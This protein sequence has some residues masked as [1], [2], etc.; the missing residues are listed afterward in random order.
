M[1]NLQKIEFFHLKFREHESSQF[2]LGNLLSRYCRAI[3]LYNFDCE[4][5]EYE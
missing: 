2:F 3:Y 4:A 1:S 5:V